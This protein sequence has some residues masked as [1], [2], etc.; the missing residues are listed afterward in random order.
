[1]SLSTARSASQCH[2]DR[3]TLSYLVRRNKDAVASCKIGQHEE[4]VVALHPLS[5]EVPVVEQRSGDLPQERCLADRRRQQVVA[6]EG[7][8]TLL[9]R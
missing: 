5:E 3:Y 2:D 1:V 9:G 7:I 8:A 6:M 4:L